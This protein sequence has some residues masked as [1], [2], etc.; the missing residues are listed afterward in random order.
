[1]LH[2]WNDDPFFR[3]HDSINSFL[4][5]NLQCLVD[6]TKSSIMHLLKLMIVLLAIICNPCTS[7]PVIRIYC[8]LKLL[9]IKYIK[10]VQMQFTSCHLCFKNWCM[11]F[12]FLK[13]SNYDEMSSIRHSPNTASHSSGKCVLFRIAPRDVFETININIVWIHNYICVYFQV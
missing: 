8:G 12:L 4:T 5:L 10:C 7:I 6:E 11:V 13:S 2:L 9:S 3:C 1:M